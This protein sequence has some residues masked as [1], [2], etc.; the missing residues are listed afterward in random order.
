MARATLALV[1]SQQGPAAWGAHVD[2]AGKSCTLLMFW[3]GRQFPAWTVLPTTQSLP[4]QRMRPSD[5]GG[6]KHR[7]GDLRAAPAVPPS[8]RPSGQGS[9]GNPWRV[10]PHLRQRRHLHMQNQPPAPPAP[11]L[12]GTVAFWTKCGARWG[13]RLT[14]WGPGPPVCVSGS[15]TGGPVS[16]GPGRRPGS[17]KLSALTSR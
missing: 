5:R 10:G 6:K 15:F 16:G 3:F 1:S 14:F 4:Q 13:R 12:C 9:R 7:Q 2:P 11:L 17:V 8:V